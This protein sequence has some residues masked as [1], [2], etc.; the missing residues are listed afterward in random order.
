MRRPS[1]KPNAAAQ[2]ATAAAGMLEHGFGDESC[3]LFSDGLGQ[4]IEHGRAHFGE[5]SMLLGGDPP[6]RWHRNWL[7]GQPGQ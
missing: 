7:S 1:L 6:R 3:A 2:R 4:V 5:Q